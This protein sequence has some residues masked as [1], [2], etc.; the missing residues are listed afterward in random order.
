MQTL[1]SE[2]W[3]FSRPGLGCSKDEDDAPGRCR[4]CH[5]TVRDIGEALGDRSP[6]RRRDRLT[7]DFG[8]RYRDLHDALD[9]IS[10]R[11]LTDTLRRAERDGFVSRHLDS[12]RVETTTL[13]KLTELGRSRDEPLAALAS[14]SSGNHHL[15]EDAD[16]RW[17]ARGKIG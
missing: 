14:W 17:D 2:S 7:R 15:V 6:E 12:D 5:A 4:Q 8:C 1:I 13:Y 16:R 11:A 9:G 10:N 3:S